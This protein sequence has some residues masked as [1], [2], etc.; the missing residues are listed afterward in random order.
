L[1]RASS[2]IRLKSASDLSFSISN[3]VLPVLFVTLV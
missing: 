2:C 1:V 3:Y